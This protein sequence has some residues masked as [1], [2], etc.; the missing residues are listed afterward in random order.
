MKTKMC[1]SNYITVSQMP[2]PFG[3][4][5]S[6][7]TSPEW[8]HAS[9]TLTSLSAGPSLLCADCTDPAHHSHHF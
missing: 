1:I 8:C 4:E 9:T 5:A 6:L 2:F 7:Q 3:Y